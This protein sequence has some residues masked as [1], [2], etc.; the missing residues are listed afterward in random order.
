MIRY[1]TI[2][3]GSFIMFVKLFWVCVCECGCVCVFTYGA[4]SVVGNFRVF[5]PHTFVLFV[6]SCIIANGEGSRF[7]FAFV[8]ICACKKGSCAPPNTPQHP[9][10]RG[11]SLLLKALWPQ[12]KHAPESRQRNVVCLLTLIDDRTEL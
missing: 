6:F 4:A 3:C 10:W 12:L 7:E 1:E 11:Q 8:N 9:K 2:L 5:F